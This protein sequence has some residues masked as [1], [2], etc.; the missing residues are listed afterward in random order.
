MMVRWISFVI[1]G[2]FFWGSFGC[3]S[4]PPVLEYTLARTALEAA[5]EKESARY[6]SGYWH[7]A[8]EFY[9]KGEKSY[10]ESDFVTARGEFERARIFAERAENVTRLRLFES[11]EGVP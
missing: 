1:F 10:Q 8:E 9:R 4:S 11:G 6:S 2:F 5:R 7:R 3:A